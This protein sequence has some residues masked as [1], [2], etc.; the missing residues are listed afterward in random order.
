MELIAPR[1]QEASAF[2]ASKTGY[3]PKLAVILGSGLGAFARELAGANVI[4]YAEI[5][6]FPKST[7]SG[8]AGRMVFGE[9][10]GSPVLVM[11]GRVHAYEGY[12]A[13]EV[14]FPVRV[15][16]AAGIRTLV[17]TNAAGAVNQAFRPGDLMVITDH[18]NLTGKNP[19]V[20]PEEPEL[21]PR[22]PDM[23]EAYAPELTHVCETAARGIGLNLRKGVYAGLL[24]PSYETPAEIRMLRTIGADAVGMSTVLEVVAAN[25][26]RMKVLGISCMT[27]MAAGILK[28]K[29]DHREVM[30]TGERVRGVFAELLREVLPKLNRCAKE[31]VR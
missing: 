25:H 18:L 5:P 17:I 4:P 31:E 24:G 28:K 1:I 3:R 7:V 13:M 6:H 9:F 8:H 14:A 10:A 19:L 21:G 2:V 27:N 22:F 23:T 30:E 15:L 26:A 11:S 12:S 20:G 16:A 29:L